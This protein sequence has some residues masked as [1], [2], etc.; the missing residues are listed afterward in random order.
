MSS[1]APL[2][3]R[4]L[5]HV[6]LLAEEGHFGRAA[7][8][9]FLSQSAFSRSIAAIEDAVQLRLVDRGPGFLRLTTAG[10][11]LVVRARRLLAGAS[12]LTRELAL[13]R[14]GDLG[15][16][17][18]GAGPYSGGILVAE[19][20]AELQTR[21]PQVHVRLEI[22]QSLA[23]QQWLMNEQIDF[24]IADLSELPPNDQCVIERLGSAPGTLYVRAEH[25]LAQQDAVSIE[26]LRHQHF[27]GVHLP[28]PLS[29]RLGTLFGADA[30]GLLPLVLECESAYVLRE[31][32]LR[33]DV[34]VS[35]PRDTFELEVGT[36][37]LK[38]LRVP[39]L[40]ALADDPPL[41]MDV[42]LVWLRERTPSPAVTQ[43]AELV[44][45]RARKSMMAYPKA[46]ATANSVPKRQKP[47]ATPA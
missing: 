25:P 38:R 11:R 9:A 43:L 22:G 2:N 37:C 21:H 41:R 36:G 1:S 13:L 23:L 35:A 12:D 32:M 33:H 45:A 6:V 27:A 17:A 34:I 39:E 30:E 7:E 18:L 47:P 8:R 40:D 28:R 4:Q 26:Q 3:L 42:G 24:F 19:A 14:S 20:V 15:D 29:L 10:E 5:Q 16:V 31:Y 44:R 46:G